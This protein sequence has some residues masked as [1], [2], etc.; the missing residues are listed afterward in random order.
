MQPFVAQISPSVQALQSM[1][2]KVNEELRE[3]L[4][5]FGEQA[6]SSDAMK[7]EDFFGLVMSFASSLQVCYFLSFALGNAHV[8]QKAAL[9][10]RAVSPP[11]QQA[12]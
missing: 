3:L 2:N 7:P 9:E 8:P 1:G 11:S 10:M 6:D 5:Y 4:T 12:R